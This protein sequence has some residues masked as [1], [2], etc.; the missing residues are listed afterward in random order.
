MDATTKTSKGSQQGQAVTSREAELLARFG[1]PSTLG[2]AFKNLYKSKLDVALSKYPAEKRP[3]MEDFYRHFDPWPRWV[4]KIGVEVL[5]V[6]F[7][8]VSKSVIE[9]SLQ[10]FNF[11]L[12]TAKID[13]S[14]RN[15]APPIPK[16]SGHDFGA[17]LGHMTAHMKHGNEKAGEAREKNLL[18]DKESKHYATEF[19][20]DTFQNEIAPVI[21]SFLKLRPTE[22]VEFGLSFSA[23]CGNTFTKHGGEKETPLTRIY[24]K[25]FSDWTE[26]EN[27]SGPK[28]LTEY[29]SELLGNQE[30]EKKY[31]RVK[32]ICKRMGITFKP[33]VKGQ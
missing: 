20:L 28:A 1:Q 4:L 30:F 17:I 23:A 24:R 16:L 14:N 10:C 3:N 32:V 15:E 13:G 6:S 25:I 2:Q 7:P 22:T 5:R 18:S 11:Y 33:L 31:E 27:L 9:E 29:L 26:I 12:L 21:C 19:S 8:K